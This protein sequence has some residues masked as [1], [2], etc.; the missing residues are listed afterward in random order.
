MIFPQKSNRMDI[1]EEL[2]II[3]NDFDINEELHWEKLLEYLEPAKDHD[4]FIKILISSEKELILGFN[5]F[6]RDLEKINN[7]DEFSESLTPI[8]LNKK[9]LKGFENNFII[10]SDIN[11]FRLDEIC[12]KFWEYSCYQKYLEGVNLEETLYIK[13]CQDI[14]KTEITNIYE[15]VQNNLD[16]QQQQIIENLNEAIFKNQEYFGDELLEEYYNYIL[17]KAIEYKE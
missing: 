7:L 17:Q 3:L 6:G 10:K 8:V 5:I 11:L 15:E 4:V 14:I 12:F 13:N 16:E 2:S 9:L 1:I